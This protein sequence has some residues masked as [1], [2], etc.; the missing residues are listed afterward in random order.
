MRVLTLE[1]LQQV[2]G[3]CHSHTKPPKPPKS[4]GCKGSKDKATKVKCTKGKAT[5][6]KNTNRCTPV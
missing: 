5:K 4:C 2:A 6:V 1:E 3:G